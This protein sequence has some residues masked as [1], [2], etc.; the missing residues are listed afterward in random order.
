MAIDFGLAKVWGDLRSSRS[1]HIPYSQH[2]TRFSGSLRYASLHAHLGR[3]L[4]RRDDVESLCYMLLYLFKGPLPWQGFPDKGPERAYKIF[5]SK[6]T[7]PLEDLC[8]GC[9]ASIVRYLEH[10]RNLKFD[11]EPNYGLL[12]ECLMGFQSESVF[13]RKPPAAQNRKRIRVR[14]DD[15]EK[16]AKSQKLCDGSALASDVSLC[17]Q[18]I[19]VFAKPFADDIRL[20]EPEYTQSTLT[21]RN[22]TVFMK[23]L[24]VKV[25][26]GNCV[27]SLSYIPE[28]KS[29]FA[30]YTDRQ[31]NACRI[32]RKVMKNDVG[33]YLDDVTRRGNRVLHLAASASCVVVLEEKNS[34]RHS[35]SDQVFYHGLAFPRDWISSN[36]SS[37]YFISALAYV[38][39][40]WLVVMSKFSPGA[41]SCLGSSLA[42]PILSQK[43]ELSFN[44]PSESIRSH[45]DQGYVMSHVS[46]NWGDLSVYVLTKYEDRF[47]Q[48][49]VRT[50]N[51]DANIQSQLEQGYQLASM[52]FARVI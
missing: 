40:E 34:F 22:L 29:W 6:G 3:Q 11:Q 51:I 36:W 48:H 35:I 25:S 42:G 21:G 9:P 49:S 7:T 27:S 45:W 5:V 24:R 52:T 33:T 38:G 13:I 16:L 1:S 46:S 18:W 32:L 12:R 50:R 8:D 19:L 15:N 2:L 26:S 17:Y 23:E 43:V 39:Q 28:T 37:K 20:G 14:S 10:V 30:C 31:E 47:R 4:S 44:Y 41:K